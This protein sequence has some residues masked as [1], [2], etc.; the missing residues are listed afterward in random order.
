[1]TARN[2][3][4][5]WKEQQRRER[6]SN[7]ALHHTEPIQQEFI[8]GIL[9]KNQETGSTFEPFPAG[10]YALEIKAA[11]WKATKAG[12]GHYLNLEMVVIKGKQK[13]KRVWHTLN[14]D[15]PS[16][17]AVNIAKKEAATIITQIFGEGRDVDSIKQLIKMITG[18][19]V[20]AQIKIRVDEKYGDK[21]EV[22]Y[23]NDP[24]KGKS[25][26]VDSGDPGDESGSTPPWE[27]KKKK[28]KDKGLDSDNPDDVK[29]AKKAAKKAR[30]KK[31]KK[32]AKNW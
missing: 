28:K 23:F 14:L 20:K 22:A 31:E 11:E 15:N 25:D 4:R 3:W 30:K 21:N 32:E 2:D 19:R 26:V 27:K 29:A 8:M 1:M 17:D 24:A 9:S 12:N 6:D 13:G 10:S 5:K 7:K 16:A 18:K